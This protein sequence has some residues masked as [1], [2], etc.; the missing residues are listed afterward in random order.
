MDYLCVDEGV[1]IDSLPTALGT[2]S[3]IGINVKFND[4]LHGDTIQAE[5]CEGD[6]YIVNDTLNLLIEGLHEIKEND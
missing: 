2:D 1:Y 4:I 6:S 3:I 5:F